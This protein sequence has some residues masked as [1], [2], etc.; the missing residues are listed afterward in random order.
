MIIF[1]FLFVLKFHVV[2]YLNW[3]TK[4]DDPS[5]FSFY[6]SLFRFPWVFDHFNLF[7]TCLWQHC[8]LKRYFL[9]I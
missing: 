4:K 9:Q 8:F 3:N 2:S 1:L 6:G 7:A 5:I